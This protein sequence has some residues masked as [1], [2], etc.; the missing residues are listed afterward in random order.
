T[1]VGQNTISVDMKSSPA[2][3][4]FVKIGNGK[5]ELI[6]KLIIE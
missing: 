5:Q 6:K 2:G 4:Y 1:Q 3:M